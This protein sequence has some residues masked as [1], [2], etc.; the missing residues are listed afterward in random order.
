V[1]PAHKPPNRLAF[2]LGHVAPNLTMLDRIAVG[3]VVDVL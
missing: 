3:F 1:L 2:R